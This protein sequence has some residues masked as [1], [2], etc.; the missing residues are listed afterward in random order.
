[1]R[2]YLVTA[3]ATPTKLSDLIGDPKECNSIL[4][5]A[6]NGTVNYGDAKTSFILL[7]GDIVPLS[8]KSTRNIYVSSSSKTLAV[9]LL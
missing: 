5:Q 4:L 2:S 1:M 9:G 8:T 3:P 7:A 6:V